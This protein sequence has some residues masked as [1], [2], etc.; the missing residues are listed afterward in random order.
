M[1]GKS[2]I[3][4]PGSSRLRPVLTET[5]DLS[6][7]R[8]S[9]PRG[10]TSLFT[11]KPSSVQQSPKTAGHFITVTRLIPQAR[12]AAISLSAESRENTRIALTSSASGIDHCSVSGT[13]T[14]QNS[15]TSDIGTPS[16][17]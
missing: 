6:V 1:F 8:T 17:T 15:P 16:I 11:Q 4:R 2:S 3:I 9:C 13:D 12:I 14:A 7:R 5:R 10:T